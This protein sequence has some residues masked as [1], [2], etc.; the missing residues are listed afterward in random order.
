L[1]ASHGNGFEASTSEEKGKTGRQ[2]RNCVN[3]AKS[4][5]N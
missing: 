1:L 3:P 5:M 2:G 4:F